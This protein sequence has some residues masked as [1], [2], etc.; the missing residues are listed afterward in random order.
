MV[1]LKPFK[2]TRPFNEDAKNIIAPTTSQLSDENI[3]I[4]LN[5]DDR[6]MFHLTI[7]FYNKYDICCT[8]IDRYYQNV[9]LELH[10]NGFITNEN[11]CIKFE[12]TIKKNISTKSA[13]K[14]V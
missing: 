3:Q 13:R 8:H 2:G 11:M 7:Y 10:I 4:L 6:D 9:I 5:C 1:L 12:N 14:I